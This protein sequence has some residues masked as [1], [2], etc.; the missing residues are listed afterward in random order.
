MLLGAWHL[1]RGKMEK[2]SPLSKT[3]Q[4]YSETAT[5]HG[6][7]YVFSRSLPQVDKVL[8]A[9]ITLTCLS[10]AAYWS[11]TAYGN[12]Q[13][14]LVVTTLKDP[15]KSVASLPF[16]A[17]TICTSGLDMDAVKDKLMKDFKTWMKDEGRTSV[18]KEEAKAHLEG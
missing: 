18:D 13:E 8:W 6:V 15:A 7:S 10:L 4:E 2:T 14:N 16:P 1:Y 3:L 17:V 12:W 5:V 11:I 9:F